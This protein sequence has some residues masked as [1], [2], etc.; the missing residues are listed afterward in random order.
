M[1]DLINKSIGIS[2]SFK[3]SF[4]NSNEDDIIK[5]DLKIKFTIKYE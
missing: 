5:I 4:G 3:N 1:I 2:L